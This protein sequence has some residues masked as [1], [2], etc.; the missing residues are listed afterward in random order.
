M[1][2]QSY[3]MAAARLLSA[4]ATAV[5]AAA[6]QPLSLD[7]AL[8]LSLEGQPGLSA[9]SRTAKAFEEAAVAARQLP[10]FTLRAGIQNLPVQGSDAFSLDKDFMTMRFIGIGRE[11][12]RRSKREAEASRLLAEGDVALA[13]QQLLARRIQ[14]DVMLGWTAPSR[15][16]RSRRRCAH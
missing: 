2:H 10:D 16:S 13:E 15:E 4:A 8:A 7:R 9:F 6:Q 3:R 12:V 1:M 14:R 11:Q 5:P